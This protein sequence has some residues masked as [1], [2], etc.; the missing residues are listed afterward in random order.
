MCEFDI[1]ELKSPGEFGIRAASQT[2]HEREKSSLSLLLNTH[3][4]SV[5]DLLSHGKILYGI[6]HE[7]D[8]LENVLFKFLVLVKNP[9]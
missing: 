6:F 7:D 8:L 9:V 2:G 5:F 3:T 1:K 4:R